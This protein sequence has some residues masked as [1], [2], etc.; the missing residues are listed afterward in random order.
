MG[1]FQYLKRQN[2]KNIRKKTTNDERLTE[3]WHQAIQKNWRQPL[4]F[5]NTNRISY[6]FSIT[7]AHKA[8]KCVQFDWNKCSRW[9]TYRVVRILVRGVTYN[10]YVI[11]LDKQSDKIKKKLFEMPCLGKHSPWSVGLILASK[12][13]SMHP[14]GKLKHCQQFHWKSHCQ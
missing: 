10:L 13:K 2:A 8:V 6:L 3:K 9:T 11:S 14:S 4:I 7:S 1:Y 5:N 12:M